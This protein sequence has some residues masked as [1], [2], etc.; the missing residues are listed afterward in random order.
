MIKANQGHIFGGYNPS[1]WISDFS[2]SESDEAFL[3][4][5]TDG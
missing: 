4:S 5:V 2:Y 3:F 1:S